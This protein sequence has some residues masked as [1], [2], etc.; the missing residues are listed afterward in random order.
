MISNLP[1]VHVGSGSRYV[2]STTIDVDCAFDDDDT[3]TEVVELS[4][5]LLR[6]AVESRFAPS[7][8]AR[9]VEVKGSRILLTN[10]C[11]NAFPV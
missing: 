5:S 3:L 9:S 1:S 4:A 11:V 6:A 8:F 10:P 2:Q 7:L